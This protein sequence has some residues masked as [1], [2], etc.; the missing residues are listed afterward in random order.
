MRNFVL[1]VLLST[2]TINMP[3]VAYWAVF[4]PIDQTEAACPQEVP[5]APAVSTGPYILK[6]ATG[7]CYALPYVNPNGT[8]AKSP[9]DWVPCPK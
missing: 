9:M 2:S 5:A 3:G 6:A 4:G 1:A 8:I 7:D